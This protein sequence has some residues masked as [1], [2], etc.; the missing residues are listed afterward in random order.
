MNRQ[1]KTVKLIEAVKARECLWKKNYV[2]NYENLIYIQQCW[3]EVAEIVG[4]SS[5][6]CRNK[7]KHLRANC[8]KLI[9]RNQNTTKKKK[10]TYRCCNFD[11]LSFIHDQFYKVKT[12]PGE[13][14]KRRS[15][16]KIA[17]T[18]KLIELVEA[19]EILWNRQSEDFNC[20][21]S[22]D[23]AW[24]VIS[25][26]LDASV[27]DVR[28]AWKSIRDQVRR[29]IRQGDTSGTYVKRLNFLFKDNP[30][31]NKMNLYCPEDFKLEKQKPLIHIVKL[32]ELVQQNKIIWKKN[33]KDDRHYKEK[34]VESWKHIANEMGNRY[35]D[36]Q[37]RWRYL[38]DKAKK[39]AKKMASKWCYLPKM[40]FYL[41]EQD[42]DDD[43]DDHT[44][45]V[46]YAVPI[47]F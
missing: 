14:S 36:L 30:G 31:L 42:H 27:H 25:D 35:N 39:E 4:E 32:I 23:A 15:W 17:D 46:E 18:D 26:E 33:A 41:E 7:W 43:D 5:V 38:K 28:V 21:I 9:K 11:R 37:N 12:E 8:G 19:H 40:Q 16:C 45:P 13:P 24:K 3:D 34:L 29:K 44:G 22:R 1:I 2:K 10:D 6:T 20:K 47:C